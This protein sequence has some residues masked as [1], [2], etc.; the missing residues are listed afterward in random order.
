MRVVASESGRLTLL[1]DILEL[2][3]PQGL[4]AVEVISAVQER[5]SFLSVKPPT[6]DQAQIRFERGRSPNGKMIAQFEIH[7]HGL[8]IDS[9]DTE[10]ADLFLED[11]LAEGGKQFGLQR[12]KSPLKKIYTSN[13]IVEL[14]S[15]LDTLFVKHKAI[16]GTFGSLLKRYYE[17]EERPSLGGMTLKP[18]PEKLPP[19]LA[20]LL[21]DF[22]IERRIF[23]PYSAHRYYSSAPLPTKDHIEFLGHLE[24]L[25]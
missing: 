6:P 15:D 8:L 24:E 13:L 14:Q 9:L 18:D 17:I 12:V 11:L 16:F 21:A 4:Y 22:R 5:Y 19:R 23:A 25:A 10:S 7:Q 1:I 3:P 2:A 20:G